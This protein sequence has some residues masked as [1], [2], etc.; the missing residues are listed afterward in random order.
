MAGFGTPP[1]A[2]PG[3]RGIYCGTKDGVV[4]FQEKDLAE[5]AGTLARMGCAVARRL[6]LEGEAAACSSHG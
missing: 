4:L 3:G 6:G 2:V 5:F 1:Q